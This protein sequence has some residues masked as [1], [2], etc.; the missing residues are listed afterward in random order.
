MDS[1]LFVVH[2]SLPCF[3]ALFLLALIV[4]LPDLSA[5]Y[6]LLR[7][8]QQLLFMLSL[9]IVIGIRFILFFIKEEK[10]LAFAGIIIMIFFLTLTGC[11]SHLM[12]DYNH[13]MRL[14]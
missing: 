2:Y 9:L 11:V 4:L 7:M 8:F 12:G 6:G 10:R 5:E 3:G 14:V 1:D 13:I